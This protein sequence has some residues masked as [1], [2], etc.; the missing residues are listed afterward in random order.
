MLKSQSAGA[1]GSI[2]V[3]PFANLSRDPDQAYFSD[4]LA[5]EIRSALARI[6]GLKV[7]G[8]TS[9]EAVRDEDAEKASKRLGVAPFFLFAAAATFFAGTAF[10]AVTFFAAAAFFEKWSSNYDR[11]PGDAIKIQTDI[12]E[13]VARAL[14]VALGSATRAALTVGGTT[15]ADAQ[16]LALQA[17]ELANHGSKKAYQRAIELIDAALALDPHAHVVR[18]VVLGADFFH[19]AVFGQA[20]EAPLGVLL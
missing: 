20:L 1:A 9:S 11:S 10:F 15:N 6:A 18:A 4:G 16:N 19:Q 2:A 8:R 7:V 13:N 17:N 3:L 12:A 14:S 5:E